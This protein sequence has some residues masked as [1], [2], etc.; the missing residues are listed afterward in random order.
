MRLVIIE[1]DFGPRAHPCQ[2]GGAERRGKRAESVN[3]LRNFGSVGAKVR[4]VK[5]CFG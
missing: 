2:T 1:T 5:S 4:K 3:G